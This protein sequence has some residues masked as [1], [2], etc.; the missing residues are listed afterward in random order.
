MRRDP[1]DISSVFFF[2]P[3]LNCY[4][5][6]P[7]RDTSRPPLTLW[8]LREVRRRLTE[9][10]ERQINEDLIFQAYKRMQTIEQDAVNATR[11]ARRQKS[12][13][14][15]TPV[16]KTATPSSAPGPSAEAFGEILP[17]EEIEIW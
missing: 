5:E 8:E 2:D 14:P 12:A 15:T 9:G 10:G 17:S 13:P 6:I 7:Y 16:E 4:F 11:K 3:E 1:R